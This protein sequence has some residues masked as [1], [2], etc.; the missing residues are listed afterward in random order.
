MS[1]KQTT[2]QST[3]DFCFEMKENYNTKRKMS[4]Q[5]SILDVF[6]VTLKVL[7]TKSKI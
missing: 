7:I 2:H 3:H 1:K 4:K 6:I 5:N